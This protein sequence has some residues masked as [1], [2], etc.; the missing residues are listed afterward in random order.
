VNGDLVNFLGSVNIPIVMVGNERIVGRFT[1]A[2]AQV[3]N[4][5]P[6]DVGRPLSDM[7]LGIPV[8][9]LG[10]RIRDVMDTLAPV[11]EEV[12]DRSGRGYR[13]LIKPYRTSDRRIDGAVLAFLDIDRLR[14]VLKSD[15]MFDNFQ[16][17]NDFPG[18]GRKTMRLHARKILRGEGPLP[19]IL[20]AVEEIREEA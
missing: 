3:L 13:M 15:T 10:N 19:M 7:N 1:P 4:L 9:D 17:E 5:I 16:V 18:L 2:A 20:L 8:P 14:R 11:E 12:Q 6:T